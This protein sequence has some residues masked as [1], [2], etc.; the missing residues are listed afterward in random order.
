MGKTGLPPDNACCFAR[1]E[2]EPSLALY[3]LEQI[4]RLMS[5]IGEAGRSEVVRRMFEMKGFDMTELQETNV[6][7][8]YLAALMAIRERIKA[9]PD[10]CQSPGTACQ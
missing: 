2:M 7:E 8:Y 4:I 10:I 3:W 9:A 1:F 5:D 6:G